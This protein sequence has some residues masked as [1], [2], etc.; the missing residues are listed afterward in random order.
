MYTVKASP[1]YMLDGFH[2]LDDFSN[3]TMHVAIIG[4]KI[5]R[6]EFLILLVED[7]FRNFQDY[8]IMDEVNTKKDRKVVKKLLERDRRVIITSDAKDMDE[9]ND[10]FFDIFWGTDLIVF[11]IL[12]NDEVN[13]VTFSSVED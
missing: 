4:K 11:E 13:V 7:L 5:D 3:L 12:E 9:F 2:A 6:E 1:A 8:V 10:K